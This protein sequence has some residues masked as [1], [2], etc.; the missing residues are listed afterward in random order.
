MAWLFQK[1]RKLSQEDLFEVQEL[2]RI[3]M[4]KMWELAQVRKNTVQIT[5]GQQYIKQL[6]EIVNV[7]M[8]E[9][10]RVVGMMLTNLGCPQN[11]GHSINLKTGEI[12]RE[13][14]PVQAPMPQQ[15]EV[16]LSEG[17]REQRRKLEHEIK[18]K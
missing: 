4:A 7:L 12:T 17:N 10:N 6:E 16:P 8:T 2:N 11:K 3:I 13:D 18:T 1:N 9:K 15:P 14:I 5:N